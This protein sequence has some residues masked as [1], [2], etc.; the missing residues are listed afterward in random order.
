[1]SLVL[2]LVVVVHHPFPSKDMPR[3]CEPGEEMTLGGLVITCTLAIRP[4]SQPA[5][6]RVLDNMRNPLHPFKSIA[7]YITSTY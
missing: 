1:M 6:L 3:D 4:S 7:T 5:P 2:A